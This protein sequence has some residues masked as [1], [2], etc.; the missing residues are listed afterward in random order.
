MF[1]RGL[2]MR[3]ITMHLLQGDAVHGEVGDELFARLFAQLEREKER[4]GY[5]IA[6]G[7][8]RGVKVT[9]SHRV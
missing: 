2:V 9:I 1:Q 8:K 3:D 4:G 7:T 6:G 5:E